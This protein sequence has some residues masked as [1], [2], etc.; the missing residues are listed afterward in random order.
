[1]TAPGLSRIQGRKLIELL[2]SSASR[3]SSSG[4]QHGVR[5]LVLDGRLPPGTRLPAERELAEA[6]GASRTLVARALELLRDEGF[7]ASRRGAGSWVT[8]PDT[9]TE[10]ANGGWFPPTGADILN[11]AQ[12]TPAAPPELFAASDRARLR[13]PEELGGHGYQPHGL[14]ALRERIAERFTQRGLPT[15]PQQILVTNGAQHAF[16]LALRT[17]ISPGDRVLLEHPTYPN[18]LEAI[19]GVNATPVAVPMVSDG[20]DLELV[21]ASVKQVSPRLAYLIPD[22]HNPTGVRMGESDRE[23]L[24]ATLRS[25]RTTA[26]ID[27]TLVDL[28]LTGGPAPAPMASFAPE[29]LI[30]I[31]SAS[32]SFWGGLRLGWMR[33]PEEL[34]Q[35]VVVGRAALDMGSPVLEQL[36][37]A[38]LL[39]D[40]ETV[41][42]RRRA[43]TI[44]RRDGL[45]AALGR[46]L[47]G[48]T[49][50]VPGGGLSLWCDIGEPVGSRLAVA[51]EQHGVRLAA[52]SR[53]AVHGSLERYVRLPYTLQP[54]QLEEAVRRLA[55]ASVSLGPGASAGGEIPSPDSAIT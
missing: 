31:G 37:L 24:A 28:D 40:R 14:L 32:K 44:T 39:A 55:L 45:I 12:A 52:G 46:N 23:R 4:L 26:V 7:I 22:F 3:P 16:A 54:E 19:R 6:L 29:R 2:G 30:V 8:L 41:V 42:R 1:M 33:A 53:F 36:V 51:A 13:L 5:Q 49:F 35:R 25:T 47:P 43:E 17:L 48:W 10:S 21:E 15:N 18:A 9:R 11:L 38:E 34:V 20:W 27:E 50:R